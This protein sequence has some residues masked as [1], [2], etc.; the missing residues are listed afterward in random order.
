[1]PAV[2]FDL[3]RISHPRVLSSHPVILECH[4][5]ISEDHHFIPKCHPTISDCHP[6]IPECHLVIPK[7]HPVISED[8]PVIPECHP[9]MLMVVHLQ[10]SSML[11]F[12]DR[13]KIG[14]CLILP[15]VSTEVIMEFNMVIHSIPSVNLLSVKKDCWHFM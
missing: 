14:I 5:V 12:R 15:S 11:A 1:M 13:K 8:H 2:L 4:P 3:R 10:Y 9:A 7:C 6:V